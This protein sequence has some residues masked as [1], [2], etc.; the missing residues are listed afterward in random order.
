MEIL[1]IVVGFT[2]VILTLFFNAWLARRQQE[3]QWDADRRALRT[4]LIVE[5]QDRYDTLHRGIQDLDNSVKARE[6]DGDPQAMMCIKFSE[7]S[8]Y[9][10]SLTHLGRLTGSEADAVFAA[11]K[12]LSVQD[13]KVQSMLSDQ[14]LEEAYRIP[15]KNYALYG[16]ALAPVLPR[17]EKAL[18]ELR[19][20]QD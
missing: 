10:A 12:A 13:K 7:A 8:I 6:K 14:I 17:I 5:L 11:Y 19:K 16:R 3:R 20:N 2:G 18:E 4:R 9:T 15:E 1:G